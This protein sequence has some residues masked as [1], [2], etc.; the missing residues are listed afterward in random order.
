MNV[1]KYPSTD[2][3]FM[4]KIRGSCRDDFER[5]IVAILSASSMH[6][7][8]LVAQFRGKKLKPP[9][10]TSEGD[11]RW[12]RVKTD[13]PMTAR[14]PPGDRDLVRWWL[15][16]YPH[17]RSE[18]AIQYR[19]KEIGKRAGFPD[20]SPNSFRVWRACKLLD[21]GIS[22]HTV[23]HLIGCSLTTLM[24]NYAQLE[25]ARRVENVN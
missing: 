20:L 22:P 3:L 10:L 16:R 6:V 24:E 17:K 14:V 15:D 9:I 18:R 13:R 23:K 8:N 21:E 12:H 25:D 4:E 19:L 2:P 7:A 5:G 1:K 11:L